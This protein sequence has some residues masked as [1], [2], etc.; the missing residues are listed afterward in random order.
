[1]QLKQ[2]TAALFALLLPACQ[3]ASHDSCKNETL[4]AY[5]IQEQ[6]SV[7]LLVANRTNRHV[8]I[9][10]IDGLDTPYTRFRLEPVEQPTDEMQYEEKLAM[11]L[12][13]DPEPFPLNSYQIA[14]MAITT[15]QARDIYCLPKGCRDYRVSFEIL[16]AAQRVTS[17]PLRFESHIVNLCM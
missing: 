8:V 3:P 5:A 15:G 13:T 10:R 7:Y 2:K 4:C 1:M 14:G 17:G 6:D 12:G 16:S 9:P 11:T